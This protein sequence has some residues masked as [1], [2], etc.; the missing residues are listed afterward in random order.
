MSMLMKIQELLFPTKMAEAKKAWG[1]AWKAK[2]DRYE[3]F[4]LYEVIPEDIRPSRIRELWEFANSSYDRDPWSILAD[5]CMDE[6]FIGIGQ[7]AQDRA[8]WMG[9]PWYRLMSDVVDDH[10]YTIAD[11]VEYPE[12]LLD[13]RGHRQPVG[14]IM[15]R[16]GQFRMWN[17]SVEEFNPRYDCKTPPWGKI[18]DII[19]H[20]M[21]WRP[22]NRDAICDYH[23]RMRAEAELTAF[24]PAI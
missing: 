20:G 3:K 5:Y 4:Q 23:D 16:S 18:S 1:D 21:N 11:V 9:G 13:D 14:I 17:R 6:G 7:V 24:A 8:S 12:R 10:K 22:T 19:V 15:W 2:R